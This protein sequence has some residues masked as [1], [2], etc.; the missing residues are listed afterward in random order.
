MGSFC[1]INTIFHSSDVTE[2]M[3]KKKKIQQLPAAMKITPVKKRKKT[4]WYIITK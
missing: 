1:Y 2:V 3:K 4:L